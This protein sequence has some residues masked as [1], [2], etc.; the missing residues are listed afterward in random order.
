MALRFLATQVVFARI[1]DF[2]RANFVNFVR[3]VEAKV[4]AFVANK[5]QE[6]FNGETMMIILQWKVA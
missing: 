1:L 2:Q 6:D 5:T 4:L 3:M